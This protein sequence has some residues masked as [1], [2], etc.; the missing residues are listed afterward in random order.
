MHNHSLHFYS[1]VTFCMRNHQLLFALDLQPSS[2]ICAFGIG[3]DQTSNFYFFFSPPRM[4]FCRILSYPFSHIFSTLNN[5]SLLGSLSTCFK[6]FSICR[7]STLGQRVPKMHAVF[8]DTTKKHSLFP[9][10]AHWPWADPKNV[11]KQ[12]GTR[13]TA[14]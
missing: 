5:L 9:S 12:T 6:T 10:L 11:E 14:T 13:G 3:T 1:S 2:G 7:V 4:G 8:W